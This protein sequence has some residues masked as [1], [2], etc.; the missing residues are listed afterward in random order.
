VAGKKSVCRIVTIAIL[1]LFSIILPFLIIFDKLNPN[2][3]WEGEYPTASWLVYI[4]VL[5][6]TFLMVG[7][8]YIFSTVAYPYSNS[9]MV[10]NFNKNTN[11][12]FGSEFSRCVDRMTRMISELVET[13]DFEK[14]TAIMEGREDV[15]KKT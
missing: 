9:L 14:A 4:F 13:K 15:G 6:T 1:I 12:K 3:N 7:G 8:E 2:V 11:L 5:N 10:R